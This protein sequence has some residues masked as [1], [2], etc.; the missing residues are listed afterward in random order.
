MALAF[1]MKPVA[2][3]KGKSS[4]GDSISLAGITA[5]NITPAQAAAQANKLLAI[6]G[7]NIVADTNMSRSQFE[8]VI[9]DD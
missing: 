4:N 3:L 7:K 6:G 8:E 5:G 2:T 1:N 9:D